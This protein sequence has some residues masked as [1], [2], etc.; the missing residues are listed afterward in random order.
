[1]NFL[2][3]PDSKSS[4]SEQDAQFD[5][6]VHRSHVGHWVVGLVQVG[7]QVQPVSLG[8]I[9]RLDADFVLVKPDVWVEA[10]RTYVD[11]MLAVDATRSSSNVFCFAQRVFGELDDVDVLVAA[12][13]HWMPSGCVPMNCRCCGYDSMLELPRRKPPASPP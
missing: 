10:R 9:V 11:A 7:H 4:P 13:A 8:K 2:C 1:M 3:L 12:F 5:F 6:H